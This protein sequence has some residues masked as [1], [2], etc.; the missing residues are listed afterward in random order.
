MGNHKTKD[1]MLKTW[2]M[3]IVL[4][5][6]CGEKSKG[7]VYFGNL[8]EG[9]KVNSPFNVEL[10]SENLIIEPVIHGVMQ[11]HGHIVLII[12]AALPSPN[13]VVLRD[14]LHLHFDE[15]Q[16][17]TVLN[18]SEGKHDLCVFFTKGNELPYKPPIYQIIHLEVSKSNTSAP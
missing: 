5:L 16:M 3:A 14:N 12:D 7:K 11:G 2:V 10:K 17:D 1:K 9:V 4:L 15:G 18:L 8:M 6:G 13:E